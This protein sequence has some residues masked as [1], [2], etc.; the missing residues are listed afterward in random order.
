[1][2]FELKPT[3]LVLQV[4]FTASG[5]DID[6]YYRTA[7]TKERLA[8]SNATL[9][10]EKNRV[11]MIQNVYPVQVRFGK[12]WVTGF[13]EGAF[14]VDG[15]PISSDPEAE[16][17]YPE[18]RDLLEEANPDALALVCRAVVNAATTARDLDSGGLE[19]V[20]ELDGPLPSESTAT[21][22]DATASVPSA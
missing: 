20:E 3:R 8:Y 15:K 4:H 11:L 9:R 18:W 7:T 22:P 16:N 2:A 21:S 17:Y 1:M 6:L 12:M 5:D 10:R 14:T 13:Q 19:F